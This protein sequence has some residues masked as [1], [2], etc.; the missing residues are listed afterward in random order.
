ML[1]THDFA[2]VL[3]KLV[4]KSI[5]IHSTWLHNFILGVKNVSYYPLAIRVKKKKTKKKPWNRQRRKL[6][7]TYLLLFFLSFTLLVFLFLHFQ[8]LY[9]FF[10]TFFLCGFSVCHYVFF[11]LFSSCISLPL[12]ISF[13]SLSIFLSFFFSSGLLWANNIL[14]YCKIIW[15]TW[16]FVP[17][18]ICSVKRSCHQIVRNLTLLEL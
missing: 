13:L 9:L 6:G 1:F 4:N 18:K 15:Q 2:V 16:V 10:M 11:F 17:T 14:F 12:Y 5:K 3:F 8:Q 7:H